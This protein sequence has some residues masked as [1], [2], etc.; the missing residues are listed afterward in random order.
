LYCASF[1][2]IDALSWRTIT[3]R[4]TPIFPASTIAFMRSIVASVE[5][6]SSNVVMPLASTSCDAS[7]SSCSRARARSRRG[8]RR[9]AGATLDQ[10]LRRLAHETGG[11]VVR[12]TQDLSAGRA[13]RGTPDADSS[14]ALPFANAA[15]PL[16]WTSRTGLFGETLSREACVGKPSTLGTAT[17]GPLL[18][19]PAA[20][21]NPLARLGP[22]DSL[23]DHRD[24]LV[25]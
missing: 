3:Q 4:R 15:W 8:R 20:A 9:S 1:G 25:P 23:G 19:V 24:D 18:L 5:P 21:V 2:A 12:V 14:I 16:A 17:A 22:R 7:S 6:A 13:L 10:S 11:I